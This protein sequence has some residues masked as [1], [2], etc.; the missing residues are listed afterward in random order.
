[1]PH[2]YPQALDIF[3]MQNK[4]LDRPYTEFGGIRGI[5][6]AGFL[7][8][9]QTAVFVLCG[10]NIEKQSV[11]IACFDKEH[12]FYTDNILRLEAA[13]QGGLRKIPLYHVVERFL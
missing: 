11:A 7:P 1:M 4:T 10:K 12:W 2:I 3:F 9:G 5:K 6:H 8:T 13:E